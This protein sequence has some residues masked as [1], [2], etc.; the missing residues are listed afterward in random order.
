MI[1]RG[2]TKNIKQ[3]TPDPALANIKCYHCQEFGHKLNTYPKR[4]EVCIC[5]GQVE[6]IEAYVT[7]FDS[8][9]L[10]DFSQLLQ[11]ECDASITGVGAVLS[12]NGHPRAFLSEN[13]QFAEIELM[14]NNCMLYS[15][16]EKSGNWPDTEGVCGTNRPPCS[17]ANQRYFR[18]R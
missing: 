17:E 9:A 13:C 11:V 18:H 10:P 8:E 15:D 12:Q 7:D 5:E 3:L 14:N 1:E 2:D 16:P 6:A 4:R